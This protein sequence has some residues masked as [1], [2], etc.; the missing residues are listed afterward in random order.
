MT[1]EKA[2]LILNAD[3]I[4]KK[5]RRIAFEI[6]E[7]NYLEPRLIIAGITGRGYA[8]AQMIADELK[9]ISPFKVEANTLILVKISLEKFASSQGEVSLD[10][11]PDILENASI[12]LVD[13]VLNT[14]KTLAHSLEPFLQKN[15]KKIEIAVLVNRSHTLFPISADYTGYELATTLQEHIEVVLEKEYLAV[16]LK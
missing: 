10:S 7:R 4:R 9:E 16:Y 11:S 8:L 3:Q 2:R 13:D 1:E 15:I 5:V 14:G 6:Y 12:V